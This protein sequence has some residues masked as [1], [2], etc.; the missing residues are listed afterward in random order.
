MR[1]GG[2]T[3]ISLGPGRAVGG[4]G[5]VSRPGMEGTKDA[6]LV[7][8]VSRPK[9]DTFIVGFARHHVYVCAWSN[10]RNRNGWSAMT[11]KSYYQE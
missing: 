8:I 10:G 1:A 6:Q 2:Y 11:L 9:I 5:K 4:A 3:A 7:G